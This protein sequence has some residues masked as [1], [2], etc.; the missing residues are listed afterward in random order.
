MRQDGSV[1]GLEVGSAGELDFKGVKQGDES[2]VQAV[3]CS[4]RRSHGAHKLQVL[5]VLPV[6]LLAAIV[7]TLKKQVTITNLWLPSASCYAHE[8][9]LLV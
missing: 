5:H 7:Q 6:Q 4:S 9:N 2:G 1:Y 3:A 8:T